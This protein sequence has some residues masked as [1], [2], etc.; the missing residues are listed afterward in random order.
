MVNIARMYARMVNVYHPER[1]FGVVIMV[2]MRAYRC[3]GV[4]MTLNEIQ[5]IATAQVGVVNDH[6]CDVP[7]WHDDDE[8]AVAQGFVGVADDGDDDYYPLFAEDID[9]P[10]DLYAGD[11]HDQ[12]Y[13][14]GW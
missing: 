9:E 11:W 5:S 8:D 10:I 3:Y 6:L 2:A 13:G 1:Q 7:A 14:D 12:E 4:P